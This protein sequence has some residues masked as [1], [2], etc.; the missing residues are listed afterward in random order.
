[1]T[2][3]RVVGGVFLDTSAL[4]AL[5]NSD[6]AMHRA[7]VKIQDELDERSIPLL[8]SEWVLTEF[9]NHTSAPPRREV[10]IKAVQ[11]LRE[12]DHLAVHP[13]SSEGWAAAFDRYR[14]RPDHGWSLVDCASMLICEEFGIR[15]V[16]THD[17][18]FKQAGFEIL[19]R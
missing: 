4:L 18:H 12:L 2:R 11:S 19:I 3:P 13:A 15:R 7:A 8:T 6:D 1:M 14:D 16:F 9:L 10:G 17:R 5:V